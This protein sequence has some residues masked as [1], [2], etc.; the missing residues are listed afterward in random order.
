MRRA[1]GFMALL[2]LAR[3]AAAEL[4]DGVAAI[5]DDEV[6]LLSEVHAAAAPVMARVAAERGTVPGE[7]A[8]EILTQA[9]QALIDGRLIADAG[10]RLGLEASE[11][12]V[13]SA[14][15]SIATEEGVSTDALYAAAKRQGLARNEYRRKLG[16]EITRMKVVSAAVRSRV[17]V[18]DE[19]VR[20]LFER[21]Y[22][23]ERSGVHVRVRHILLAWP[24]TGDPEA[25]EQ[26]RATAA[27]VR[28]AASR[29]RDFGSL[30]RELSAAPSAPEGGLTLFREGEVAREL[31]PAVFG[32]EPGEIS[33]PIETA[34]GVNLILIV[35]RFDPSKIG[36]EEV[37]PALYGEVLERKTQEEFR[38][39]IEELRANRYIEVVAPELR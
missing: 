21:R 39:W 6:I 18:S 16:E 8:D 1:A 4:V 31:E 27:E 36:L 20:E 32:L 7:V 24:P 11:A 29:G 35:E 33:E 13:D 26:V 37:K 38:P 10:R 22:R 15:A 28:D 2:L 19:D 3:P 5:V 30:A 14:V 25:R 23:G 34:H 12:D 9:L 17:S